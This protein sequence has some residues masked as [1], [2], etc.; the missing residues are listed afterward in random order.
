MTKIEWVRN[1][2]GTRGLTWNP[3]VG[4]SIHSP[5]CTNCYAM[6]QAARLL[7]RPGSHYQGTTKR[8]N[9]NA[10]WTG[11][12][13]LAPE[14]T[15]LAPF[16]RKKPATY[17]VNSMSDLFH[18]DIPIEWIML[19]YAVMAATPH[20]TY[21]VLTKR[22]RYMRITLSDEHF[23]SGVRACQSE[24]G[25]P[26]RIS[27]D[28]IWQGVSAEDQRRWDERKEDLR[29]TPAA[30]HFV[31]F[32]PLLGPVVEP[33][34]IS[35]FAQWV[36]VGGESGPG[37]RLMHLEWVRSIRDQCRNA[38]VAFFF[39]QWGGLRPKSGGR[40]LDRREWNDFPNMRQRYAV[41]AE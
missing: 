41:A 20:H 6:R 28:H 5:G 16:R 4:C 12:L 9:G 35:D 15:L 10:V 32:E 14:A 24:L 18:E 23:W 36:I 27:S 13:A 25:I 26:E 21:Q 40:L 8:V 34:P 29:N 33:R 22:A 37:A 1:K 3:V 38:H 31:S 7:D 19:T 11:K 30:V 2:D 17:F 39:K